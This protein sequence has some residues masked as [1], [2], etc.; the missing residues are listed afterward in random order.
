MIK[1]PLKITLHCKFWLRLPG[2]SLLRIRLFP[3]IDTTHKP[4]I[5]FSDSGT[6]KN[7]IT[8]TGVPWEDP[9]YH[10]EYDALLCLLCFFCTNL[11]YTFFSAGTLHMRATRGHSSGASG[12][13][14]GLL[15]P[16]HKNWWC[17]WEIENI[18]S[19]TANDNVNYVFFS[20]ENNSSHQQRPQWS[21][22]R[23]LLAFN[24]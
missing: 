21:S 11:K 13:L 24:W 8:K 17:H 23:W 5:F 16:F 9:S 15:S 4:T 3:K 14:C 20:S 7:T 19:K 12:V 2:K 22:S 1:F 6:L 10:W 18:G